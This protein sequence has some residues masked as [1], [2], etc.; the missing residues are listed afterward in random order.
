V[1]LRPVPIPSL[2][3]PQQGHDR[4]KR[5][6][7]DAF[8]DE[9]ASDF[10]QQE[11]FVAHSGAE[12]NP[13]GIPLQNGNGVQDMST[14]L[15][16]HMLGLE[17]AG[18]DSSTHYYSGSNWYPRLAQTS[19]LQT[20]IPNLQYPLSADVGGDMQAMN[21]GALAS[22]VAGQASEWSPQTS[23]TPSEYGMN[24]MSYSFDFGQFGV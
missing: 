14:R 11:Q 24:N 7:Q 16:A 10:S 1:Q 23:A 9:K 20:D 8:E 22:S 4:H 18:V 13:V 5:P 19:T 6:A 17:V 21:T 2:R 3:A 15:M 12:Q